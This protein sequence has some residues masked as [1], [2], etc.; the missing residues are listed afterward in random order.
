MIIHEPKL[1]HV[2]NMNPTSVQKYKVIHKYVTQCQTT[3]QAPGFA[4]FLR[5]TVALYQKC[6]LYNNHKLYIDYDIHPIFSFFKYDKN[7]YIKDD[8]K[9]NFYEIIYSK[10]FITYD[11]I[12]SYIK[13]IF[14][15]SI[16]F[17][18]LTNSIYYQPINQSCKNFLRTLTCPSNQLMDVIEDKK[19]NLKIISKKYNCL[20]IRFGDYLLSYKDQY[21][22]HQ[23]NIVFEKIKNS[24]IIN[25]PLVLITDSKKMGQIIKR[26][27][28]EILYIDN[29]KTHSGNIH[30]NI[31]G[32]RDVLIDFSLMNNANTIYSICFHPWG[33]SGFSN[34]A[35]IIHDIPLIKL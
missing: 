18:I 19:N 26:K 33:S 8:N 15:K 21:N 17:S 1:D 27:I 2:F 24:N 13:K 32:L 22:L 31:E 34:F 20:H 6:E 3:N 12:D 30:H 29:N 23:L 9:N 10:N 28:P 4:D 16:S 7:I 11:K 14:D 25:Y 5:G 35:S